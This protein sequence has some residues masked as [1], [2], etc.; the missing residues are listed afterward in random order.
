MKSNNRKENRHK[1]KKLIC[2]LVE[3]DFYVP[4]KEKELAL[5]MQIIVY[6][7]ALLALK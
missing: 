4:M 1:R 5:F 6:T 3:G 7:Q 2:D